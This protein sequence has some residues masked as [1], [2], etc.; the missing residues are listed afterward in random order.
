MKARAIRP[1]PPANVKFNGIYFPET[2]IVTSNIVLNWAH[3]NRLQQTG[4][5][6]IGWYDGNV[7]VESGVTYAYELIS[8]NVVLDSQSNISANTVT[9]L[10]SVLKPNKPHT[11]KLWSV[12]DGYKSYQKFEHSF[13]VEAVSL[14]LTATALKDKV[15]GSTVPVANISVNVDESLKANMKFDGS[16]ISGKAPAGSTITIEVNE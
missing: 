9:I 16:S 5:E 11:L 14:I 3:R 1:Y 10:A 2:L 7:T 15:V 4:G 13:F 6:I 12:R 8:E